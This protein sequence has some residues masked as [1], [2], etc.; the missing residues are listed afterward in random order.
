MRIR[1]V[2]HHEGRHPSPKRLPRHCIRPAAFGRRE[3]QHPVRQF[4][5]VRGPDLRVRPRDPCAANIR[6]RLDADA[7]VRN[8]ALD[9]IPQLATVE[10]M[11][12][13]KL[14]RRTDRDRLPTA[15]QDFKTLSFQR[16][17]E[18]TDYRDSCFPERDRGVIRRDQCLRWAH[19]RI[20]RRAR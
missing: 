13:L 6:R 5:Q 3:D 7:L 1:W 16:R 9:G 19:P 18:P 15:Q 11:T 4:Q 20:P 10:A 17:V 8:A 14:P 12:F 2:V